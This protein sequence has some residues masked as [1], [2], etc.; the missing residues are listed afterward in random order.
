MLSTSR[1]LIVFALVAFVF[2]SAAFAFAPKVKKAAKRDLRAEVLA[3]DDQWRKA[4]SS[5]DTVVMDKLMSDD[6]L[7]ISGNGQVM[8]K[9]QQ[10]DRMRDRTMMV[11]S[12]STD[13][14]KVKLIGQRVAIVTSS[15]DL[16]GSIDGHKVHGR[17]Q[18]T[19][20]YQRRPTG[21]KITNF[22]ATPMRPYPHGSPH[23]E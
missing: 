8:T 19:R 1:R 3:I 16:D 4:T 13:D 17:F 22:E 12:L 20:V 14:V 11:T 21:W 5:N 18:S 2:A 9:L 6:Y 23:D 10:I 7:G 15:A